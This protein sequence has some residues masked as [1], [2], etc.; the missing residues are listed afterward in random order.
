MSILL[1]QNCK[2]FQSAIMKTSGKKYLFTIL[3]A[4]LVLIAGLYTGLNYQDK[5]SPEHF[6]LSRVSLPKGPDY[7]PTDWMDRQRTFPYG[8]I[9][10]EVYLAAVRQ[11]RDLN[12][13]AERSG[14]SWVFAGPD[15]I[16]GRITDIEIPGESLSTVYVAA[17]SGGI[18]KT[19]NNG[20]TWSNIF[21]DQ[22]TIPVGDIA[23][24]KTNTNLMYAGTGE[25]NSS[26]QSFRG[27]GIYKSTDGGTTWQHSGLD[28]SAYIGRI[29]IDH[30][31][32]ERVYA[33]ACGNLFTP[34]GN[35]GVYR[36]TDGGNTWERILFVS[37]STSAIDIVQHP[38]NPDILYAA[39]WERMRGLNYRRSF[40]P[41]SGIWK[42]SDGGDT[43][44][45]LTSGL[46]QNSE[47][48]RIGL[49]ISP[50]SPSVLYAFYDNQNEVAIYKTQNS[51]QNWTRTNDNNLQGMNSSFGWYF[52]Q[53]RVD[54]IN[55]QKLF[56]L[57]FVVF[58]SSDGG[59]SWSETGD[60]MHVDHHAMV[61]HPGSGRIYEG[62]DGGLYFSDN[63]GSSWFKINNLP[64]TQFYDIEI[65]HLNPLRLYGGTQ[66]NNTVRTWTGQTNNWEAILGG[67][68]FYSLVD[69]TN[70]NIIYAEYQY[71]AL[72][73]STNGGNS[74]NPVYTYWSSDRVNW[75][76]PVVM[77][78]TN[79]ATLYFGTYRVWKTTNG[80]NSWSAVSGD[81]TNGDDGS[82]FHTITT[83][84]ISTLEPDIVLAGTDDGR[85]H[86]SINGGS[87]W[88]DIS[89]GLP[90]R[91]ITR[92]A[93]DPFDVNT[94]FVTLSGFR[95]DEPL[96][97][98]FKSTNLGQTWQPIANGLPELPVNAFVADP[99][100]QGRYFVGTDAG[101]F[102][103][104]NAGETW[105][106]MNQ[107]LGN[108]PVTS[109][110]IHA[111]ENF[112]VIGTYGLS[113]YKFDLNQLNVGIEKLITPQSSLSVGN[114]YPL[115]FNPAN[116]GFL[117]FRIGAGQ[118]ANATIRIT[119]ISGKEVYIAENF[120]LGQ[121][122]TIFKWNGLSN[123]G[124]MVGPGIYLLQV[125]AGGNKSSVKFLVL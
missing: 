62:N 8:G 95:W 18:L 103:S 19:T 111:D 125:R 24:D 116:D 73:K 88:N 14:Y 32:S 1:S 36:T 93:T 3:P 92:V 33:A 48:G 56:V 9:K 121:G 63:N 35:R 51:G 22:A 60:E 44:T 86:I 113:A 122:F 105:Q 6:M 55:S 117:N 7:L 61:F 50:S 64:L 28:L 66:D 2:I 81:L 80:A 15:N 70:S 74:M 72:H 69:Y 17:A 5:I 26:S 79:P 83:L 94:I 90:Q 77:H 89:A 20:A 91:W 85:V 49:A 119:D 30:S 98:I 25:A 106:S 107:G 31:N 21:S 100:E 84:A 43:W 42:T 47:T 54:P 4:L 27:D 96:A 45:E 34:D 109:M 124:S 108:V 40:G 104:E 115:P 114:P 52:G 99:G 12:A 65:D 23:I 78:P 41:S 46:P 67:D 37:D 118:V 110:K 59:N 57:G 68:G 97:H 39:M 58:T 120:N 123:R 11:A 102:L 76:A 101:V 16:G 53:I 38:T 87:L 82:S 29:V 13:S 75:S 112:L 10:T 71:G